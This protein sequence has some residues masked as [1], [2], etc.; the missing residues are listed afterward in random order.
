[1]RLETA[2]YSSREGITSHGQA[3]SVV[4]DNIANSSTVGYKRSRTEF[5]ALLASTFGGEVEEL[6][7]GFGAAVSNVRQIHA[8]GILEF[9]GRELDVG[10]AGDG[11]FMVGSEASPA[12]TR[13]GNFLINEEGLLVDSNGQTVLGYTGSDTETLGTLNLANLNL[14]SAAT[15]AGLLFGNLDAS[16]D[17]SAVPEDI[18]SFA[19]VAESASFRGDIQVYDS[20][21]TRHNIAIAFYKTDA[22]QWTVQGYIDGAEVGAPE[23]AGVP[24][25]VGSAVTLTFTENGLIADAAAATIEGNPAYSNGAAPGSFTIDLSS[26]TQFSSASQVSGLSQDGQSSGNIEDYEFDSNGNIF[27]N[28]N[29]GTRVL[30]GSIALANFVNLD[31]LDRAGN[32]AF[33]AGDKTGERTVAQPGSSGLGV[34]EGGSLERSSVDIAEEFVELLLYQRGYQANSRMFSTTGDLLRETISLMR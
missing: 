31:G 13:A 22:N 33:V 18:A 25:K 11:F 8:P 26:L 17:I 16:S 32:N 15:S 12:Y 9:T 6:T 24:V 19:Q 2:L 10:I 30:V 21:G 5:E 20:L 7:S 27:A 3:I 23:D 14:S 29:S 34:I 4:G 28:L 1:M